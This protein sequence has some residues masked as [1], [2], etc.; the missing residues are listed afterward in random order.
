MLIKL[1]LYSLLF[2]GFACAMFVIRVK[3]NYSYMLDAWLN[4]KD[5]NVAPPIQL[6][7]P[8][9]NVV[10]AVILLLLSV[11]DELWEDFVEYLEDDVEDDSEE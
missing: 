9:L 7:I 2:V 10:L 6:L 8:V 1:Y 5:H 11:N 3:E 4:K